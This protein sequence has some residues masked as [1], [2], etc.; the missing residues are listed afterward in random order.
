MSWLRRLPL[1]PLRPVGRVLVAAVT[2]FIADAVPR[3]GASVS[4]YALFSMAPL[5]VVVLSIAALVIDAES[6]RAHLLAEVS[7]LAGSESAGALD[8]LLNAVARKESGLV[9]GAI[10]LLATALGASVVVVEL[11]AA[12]DGV[13]GFERADRPRE[14]IKRLIGA[15]LRSLTFIIAVAFLLMTTL[16][17]SATVSALSKSLVWVD[18]SWLLRVIDIVLGIGVASTLYFFLFKFFPQRPP[19]KRAAAIG[20]IS[21]AVLFAIGK[22]LIG[23]YLGY[24]GTASVFGAAGS[25]VVLMIWVYYS[26]QILLFGA[27][28][29][30]AVASGAANRPTDDD[31]DDDFDDDGL[32]PRAFGSSG[33]RLAGPVTARRPHGRLERI[34]PGDL[35]G[36]EVID[37]GVFEPP[38]SRR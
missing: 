3:K 7:A 2:G 14:S 11:K 22:H 31:L 20:A 24:A 29:A 5:I 1:G 18:W 27:E 25:I 8:R 17:L 38:S 28:I 4:Y 12:L 16:A 32:G 6:V 33:Q 21:A 15:R 13:F 23:L 19:P 10:A 9:A 26:T 36:A 37:L 34:Y 35:E 30:K